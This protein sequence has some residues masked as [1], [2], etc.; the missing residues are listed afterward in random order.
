MLEEFQKVF[1]W[2]KRELGQ[3]SLGEHSINTQGL[4]PYC[5]T[6]GW[7]SYYEEAEVNQKI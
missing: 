4:P 1:T 7:L 3:C 6:L 5:M 2:H